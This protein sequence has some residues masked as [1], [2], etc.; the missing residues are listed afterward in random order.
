MVKSA[1]YYFLSLFITVEWGICAAL[2]AQEKFHAKPEI[3]L[4]IWGLTMLLIAHPACVVSYKFA[5][6]RK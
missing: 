4:F 2:V 6:R 1:L 5:F 3:C